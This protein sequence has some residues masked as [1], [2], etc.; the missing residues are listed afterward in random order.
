MAATFFNPQVSA[1]IPMYNGSRYI[2]IAIESILAQSY[3]NYE[4]I[5]VD[6]G[7]RD[8][9][10]SVIKPYLPQIRYVY[11]DNQGV[12]AARNHGL[13]LAKGDF[14]AFLDQDDFFLPDKLAVQVAC[15]Q[16]YPTLSF[17]NSGWQIVNEKGEA[18]AAV[19]PWQG[20]PKLDLEGLV[21]W[22][23]VFL[24][25]ML[26]RRSCLELVGGFDPQLCQTP[27][28]DLV[29]RL[30]VLG[31]S[32]DWVR[33]VTVGYRQHSENVSRN[34]LQQVGELEFVVERFFAQPL[35]S[36]EILGLANQSRYQSWVWSAWRLYHSGYLAQMA[37]FLEK[38]FFLGKGSPT[39][40][41]LHWIDC[42]RS[43]ASE[44]GCE[45]DVYALSNSQEW[46][47]L[48][49]KCLMKPKWRQKSGFE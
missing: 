2:S 19:Q 45:F 23:P 8:S 6:D 36:P 5:V 49:D 42:F 20:L 26:F 16:A 18:V 40:I 28:V 41:V 25:A 9:S 27:D 35:L 34:S 11:Q 32:G 1:I 31:C 12:A 33:Q 43:Y 38:S 4:I 10:Y 47:G 7:S 22:K 39:E 29:L 30:A 37:D 46:K 17:V 13:K 24:G 44:Y 21:I 15:L 48:M 3:T 14:I